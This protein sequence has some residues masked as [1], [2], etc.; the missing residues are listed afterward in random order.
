MKILWI[1]L[2][3]INIGFT[4]DSKMSI[5][6]N[7]YIKINELSTKAFMEVYKKYGR[8]FRSSAILNACGMIK[9]S[10]LIATSQKD[11]DNFIIKSIQKD[12][13]GNDTEI[14]ISA[15][16]KAKGILAGYGLG[17]LEATKTTIKLSSKNFCKDTTSLILAEYEKQSK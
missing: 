11:I 14:G 13:K 6:Y 5:A 17:F 7:K 8:E 1:L 3:V 4:N 16:S 2:L 10:Q 15:L 12:Y 9:T